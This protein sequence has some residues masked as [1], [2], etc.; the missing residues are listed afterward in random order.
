MSDVR[1]HRDPVGHLHATHQTEHVYHAHEFGNDGL[2]CLVPRAI[3]LE[4]QAGFIVQGTISTVQATTLWAV[5][6]KNRTS[7]QALLAT[8]TASAGITAGMLVVNTTHPSVAWTY[9]NISGS[10]WMM[11]QPGTAAAESTPTLENCLNPGEVDT[12]APTDAVVVSSVPVANFA[13][14]SAVIQGE[15]A[16][17][18]SN[19]LILYRVGV[20]VPTVNA[21]YSPFSMGGGAEFIESLSGIPFYS[22]V[23]GSPGIAANGGVNSVFAGGVVPGPGGASSFT[24][25]ASGYNFPGTCYSAGYIGTGSTFDV[26]PLQGVFSSDVIFAPGSPFARFLV[27]ELE[28]CIS[29]TRL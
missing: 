2:R 23:T 24:S 17:T 19:G 12:W 1:Q 14:A 27:A 9:K 16:S 10:Q 8:F 13:S 5:T 28:R 21:G 20:R 11:T 22:T 3:L 29:T 15:N 4:N 25:A 26:E 18:F 6:A 7:N